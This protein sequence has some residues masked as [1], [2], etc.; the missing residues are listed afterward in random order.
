MT[1]AAP[2]PPGKL[3]LPWIGETLG[4]ARNNHGFYEDRFKKYGP[5]FKTRLFGLNFVV[6]SGPAAF[7]EFAISPAIER[8]GT[9]PISVEQIF[10]H[11]LALE[12]GTEHHSR[13]DVM[14][15]AVRTREAMG[16]YL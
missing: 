9:D 2:L 12:D 8:G 6:V 1:S 5:I 16:A 14:L 11:S 13:K 7:H 10:L 3:G 4:I 15:Y